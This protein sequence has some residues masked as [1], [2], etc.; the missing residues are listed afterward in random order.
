MS[1]LAC[2]SSERFPCHVLGHAC[3]E[4]ELYRYT[5]CQQRGCA[6]F[7]Y[8][9]VMKIGKLECNSRDHYYF[10]LKRGFGQ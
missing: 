10:S 7:A 2:N 4:Q 3:G 9:S 5:H 8:H 6:T 1:E